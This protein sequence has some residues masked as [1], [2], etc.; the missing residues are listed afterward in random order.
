LLDGL[1]E[2]KMLGSFQNIHLMLISMIDHNLLLL[3]SF[4]FYITKK[5]TGNG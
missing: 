1:Q 2:R 5:G 3:H 4:Y